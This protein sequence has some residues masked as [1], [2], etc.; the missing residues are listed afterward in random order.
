[1][2]VFTPRQINKSTAI[3]CPINTPGRKYIHAYTYTWVNQ[4]MAMKVRMWY[5]HS[6]RIAISTYVH[7]GQEISYFL[8]SLI[9]SVK[10]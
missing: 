1:M 10:E 4:N 5:I 8:F 3:T 7:A 2:S 9:T 6:K